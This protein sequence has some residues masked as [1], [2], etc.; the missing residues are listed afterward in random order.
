[1]DVWW[2][3]HFLCKDL[4]S[5]NWNNHFK[6]DVSGSRLQVNT[7]FMVR[8]LL[9]MVSSNECPANMR[10]KNSELVLPYRLQSFFAIW[11]PLDLRNEYLLQWQLNFKL[12]QF[13]FVVLFSSLG[14]FIL[15]G[16]TTTS[17]EPNLL[18]PKKESTIEHPSVLEPCGDEGDLLHVVQL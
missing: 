12:K 2:N 5:S 13:L 3:N 8:M 16:C 10:E 9:L 11:N 17:I 7:I 6:V 4:E 1:M 15:L 18:V 14:C